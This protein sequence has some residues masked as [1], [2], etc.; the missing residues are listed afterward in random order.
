MPK[1]PV[2]PGYEY[3][4]C[5]RN[6]AIDSTTVPSSRPL[7]AQLGEGSPQ[8]NDTFVHPLF[9]YR[10][11]LGISN[12]QYQ[13]IL[14]AI[15]IASRLLQQ[16][17]ILEWWKHTITGTL[18]YDPIRGYYLIPL[19]PEMNYEAQEVTHAVLYEHLPRILR[20]SFWALD[21]VDSLSFGSM[22]G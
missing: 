21:E 9:Q 5:F 18:Q 8:I 11:W 15:I 12:E 2:L 17:L 10:R 7:L 19:P 20:L 16:P 3:L 14:P 1:V 22:E 13:S 6:P 4:R